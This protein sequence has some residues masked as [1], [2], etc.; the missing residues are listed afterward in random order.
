MA[1]LA[2]AEVYATSEQVTATRLNNSINASTFASGAVD[3]S[4]TALSGGAIIVKDLGVTT[5]KLAPGAVTLPKMDD[6]AQDS[7]IGRDTASTGAPE[8]IAF[9]TGVKAFLKTPS[10]ANLATAVTGETGS[11][12]LVFATSPTLVTPALGTP[13][14]G[15]LTNCTGTASG[16]T[17]GVATVANGLKSATTTVSV[18][19]ATA[20]TSGQVLTA[21]GASTATWQTASG[22]G[23]VTAASNMTD[24]TM[25]KGDGGAKGIQDTGISIDDSN[26]VSS[27]GTLGCGAVTSTGAVTGTSFK[28]GANTLLSG[29]GA[30]IADASISNS[31]VDI[32]GVNADC[33]AL[34][35]VIN[36]IIARMEAGTPTIST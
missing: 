14:S 3:S 36:S 35:A 24:N 26:N 4:T 9:G 22:S 16:L 5:G 7:F 27:M 31:G 33:D 15:V 2:S 23:D 1:I 11:G 10:S 6:M 17:A 30:S 21:T 18:S 19:A 34:G 12:A 13:A 20:P 28:I 8:V 25:L 29:L 32:A